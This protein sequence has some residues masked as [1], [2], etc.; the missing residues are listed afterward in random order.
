MTGFKLAQI[1]PILKK[2]NLDP[3]SPVNYRPVTNLN[4]YYIKTI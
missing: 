1:T 3:D 4:M 2:D